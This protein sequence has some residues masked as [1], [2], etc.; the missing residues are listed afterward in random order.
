MRHTGQPQRT[1][2]CERT[3]LNEHKAPRVQRSSLTLQPV[4]VLSRHVPAF[5]A[6]L[7]CMPPATVSH[8]CST[9]AALK[10]FAASDG[11]A[12]LHDLQARLHVVGVPLWR[13][14][15]N[16]ELYP[17]LELLVSQTQQRARAVLSLWNGTC[18]PP[19]LSAASA[20][21]RTNE[22][23]Y[24]VHD[25]FDQKRTYHKSEVSL[26]A[27]PLPH[28]KTF[29]PRSIS[30]S[31][32]IIR[33]DAVAWGRAKHLWAD[34]IRSFCA[35]FWWPRTV[36]GADR[37]WSVYAELVPPNPRNCSLRSVDEL[38]AFAQ[39][40]YKV[41]NRAHREFVWFKVD[42]LARC[43]LEVLPFSCAFSVNGSSASAA[44]LRSHGGDG[45]WRGDL[46]T[47]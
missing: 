45:R 14:V 31:S 21:S 37:Q 15:A 32:E 40:V 4:P 6:V 10:G 29:E 18:D 23:P 12:L 8:R 3:L 38:G 20:A 42:L 46:G 24:S 36:R 9:V 26:E 34:L 44:P 1:T 43:P 30:S 7:M 11:G 2:A 41:D 28:R 5:Y 22:N 27:G 47:L 33:V 13:Q 39:A 35:P 25:R 16:P 19:S 17:S